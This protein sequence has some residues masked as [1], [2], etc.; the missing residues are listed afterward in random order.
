[1][2][3]QIMNL[4][5]LIM[6]A[7]CTE[8]YILHVRKDGSATA[9]ADRDYN[10]PDISKFHNTTDVTKYFKSAIISNIDTSSF[11]RIKFDIKSIDSLGFYLPLHPP[12]FIQFK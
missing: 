8:S 1:M 2:L 4:I 6:L 9:E 5:T 10:S 3:R 12:G 7:S 11:G